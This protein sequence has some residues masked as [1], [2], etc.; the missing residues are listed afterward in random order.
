M[1]IFFEEQTRSL[2]RCFY[3]VQNEVGLGRAEEAYHQA[4]RIWLHEHRLPVAFKQPHRLYLDQLEVHV[5]I[6]DLVG[7][8]CISV[9]LKAVPRRLGLS[10]WVQLIDYMKCRGDRLGLLVNFG[11][12]RVF[13]ERIVLDPVET[14]VTECWDQW[15][16]AIDGQER[17]IGAKIR[18]AMHAIYAAHTTGYGAEVVGKLVFAAF[19]HRYLPVIP[20]PIAKAFFYNTEVHESPLDCLIVS[21]KILF[22]WTALFDSN[23]YNVSRGL[24]YMKSLGLEWGVAVNFGKQRVE[25]MALRLRGNHRA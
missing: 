11:L 9:E 1:A 25:I 12:D 6:P 4:C 3:V 19:R 2:R 5:L 17:E 24:S 14:S 21:G 18:E 10:D 22:V 15:H 23:S 13:I 7:W 16:G 8:D 20:N